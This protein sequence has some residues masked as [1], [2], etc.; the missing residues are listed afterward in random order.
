MSHHNA[1]PTAADLLALTADLNYEIGMTWYLARVAI[2]GSSGPQ[3][4]ALKESLLIHA[5]CLMDFFNCKPWGDDVIASHYVPEWDPAQDG[6]P[7]LAWLNAHLEL[8]IN[9]R[10]A[11]LT[12]Y[13]Q[14]VPKER[15]LIET[16]ESHIQTL[17]ERFL[18]KASEDLRLRIRGLAS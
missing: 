10:V 2:P 17:V 14:R 6:G 15:Y 8:F 16:V 12:A 9:K 5:R 7:E 13:R 1:P 11:H 18:A 4:N 3:Q